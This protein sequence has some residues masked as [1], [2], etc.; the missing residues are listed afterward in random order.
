MERQ[1]PVRLFSLSFTGSYRILLVALLKLSRP[2]A[3]PSR[4]CSPLQWGMRRRVVAAWERRWKNL[5]E[6]T[7]DEAAI[8]RALYSTSR[9]DAEA[10]CRSLIPALGSFDRRDLQVF[11]VR[12]AD[13]PQT[14]R[15]A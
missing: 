15:S 5:L 1:A 13:R 12:R 6:P 8:G 3:F 14:V 4:S 7:L 9:C 10:D 11:A 2:A